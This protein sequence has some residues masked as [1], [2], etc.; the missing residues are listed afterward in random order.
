MLD[1]AQGTE[2]QKGKTSKQVYQEY[3]E[4]GADVITL[5]TFDMN[6]VNVVKTLQNIKQEVA[7]YR[8]LRACK[9]AVGSLGPT[10]LVL[11]LNKS[12]EEF[13]RLSS[14]YYRCVVEFYK[15]G[16]Y[17]FIIET[18]TD[19]LNVKAALFALCSVWRET[20]IKPNVIVSCS[21]DRNGYLLDGYHL[22][23]FHDMLLSYREIV[24]GFGIN[25]SFGPKDSL[26]LIQELNSYS[27]FPIT[28]YPNNGLPESGAYK[29]TPEQWLHELTPRHDSVLERATRRVNL[30]GGCC[31]TTPDHIKLLKDNISEF[32]H[33]DPKLHCDVIVAGREHLRESSFHLNIGERLNVYGSLQFKKA[34]LSE[35]TR[36][37]RE[38][39]YNQ[40]IRSNCDAI[41][42]NLDAEL[43][44]S[45]KLNIYRY[46]LNQ[47]DV[48][49]KPFV[50]DSTNFEFLIKCLKITGGRPIVN[51][52]SLALGYE[53]FVERLWQI[54]SL[55][56]TVVVMGQTESGIPVEY[57]ESLRLYEWVKRIMFNYNYSCDYFYDPCVTP[58]C[59]DDKSNK[60]FKAFMGLRYQDDVPFFLGLSNVSFA[61]K[62]NNKFRNILN[63]AVRALYH[64]STAICN[65][66]QI[67][68]REDTNDLECVLELYLTDQ[69]TDDAI[70][71][72]ASKFT[73]Q[74]LAKVEGVQQSV[75]QMLMAG[76]VDGV[77]ERTNFDVVALT[78]AISEVSSWYDSNKIQVIQ[79]LQASKTLKAVMSKTPN[80]SESFGVSG[81]IATCE[82]DIHDIGKDIVK[83]V[84]SAQGID[85]VDLGVDVSLSKIQQGLKQEHSFIALSGLISPSLESMTKIINGIEKWIDRP[86]VILIGGAVVSQEFADRFNEYTEKCYVLYG[87]DP[88]ETVRLIKEN[89]GSYKEVK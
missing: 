56:A 28:Y 81:I 57:V 53:E 12:V 30:I 26:P 9:L 10:E 88:S 8:E 67:A 31:G 84:V 59:I 83:E 29:M 54:K 19:S 14:F 50:I 33:Y 51:S 48:S 16:I 22:R 55:G 76:D 62:G 2:I 35:D 3:L 27:Q 66:D 73:D 34:V 37:I 60:R 78:S 11:S 65:V 74:K 71:N 89:C 45:K 40:T 47:S 38:I 25:C 32:E 36:T 61:F 72:Y 86:I 87:A 42:I 17:D 5:N 24:A 13:D 82:G 4:A 85:V 63:Q 41:D 39:A 23:A 21:P 6:T 75:A 46:L 70:I 44:E 7:T 43:E 77:I 69:V 49:A 80:R 52:I 15:L 20:R 79:L 18:A 68:Q 64:N 1:G 58:L